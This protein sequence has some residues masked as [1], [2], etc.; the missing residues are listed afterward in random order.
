M[1]KCDHIQTLS[2]F[3]PCTSQ[4]TPTPPDQAPV[5]F[6]AVAMSTEMQGWLKKKS[7]KTQGKKLMDVWQKRCPPNRIP[8]TTDAELNE[9]RF[10]P[11]LPK[12]FD[13][14]MG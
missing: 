6:N 1:Q 12:L 9:C 3:T 7:P 14:N 2:K 8:L 4:P 13:A 11:P 10:S 5:V